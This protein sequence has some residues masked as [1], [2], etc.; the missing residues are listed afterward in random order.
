MQ[1]C[2]NCGTALPENA[3]FCAQCGLA[4]NLTTDTPTYSSNRMIYESTT[5]QSTGGSEKEEEEE[6]RRRMLLGLPLLGPM[7]GNAQPSAGNVP[8]VQGSPFSRGVPMVQ[9]TPPLAGAPSA[10]GASPA[11]NNPPPAMTHY[12]EPHHTA[13][14]PPHHPVAP[15]RPVPKHGPGLIPILVGIPVVV[16]IIIGG[17]LG[18]IFI[19]LPP[20]L[21]LSGDTISGGTLHLHGSNFFPGG[22]VALT[23]DNGQVLTLV[24]PGEPVTVS[25]TGTFDATISGTENWSVGQHTIHA[26]ESSGGRNGVLSFTLNANHTKVTPNISSFSSPGDAHCAYHGNQGWICQAAISTS[27]QALGNLIW[28]VSSSGLN[29]ITITPASG[30]LTPG[31]AQQVTMAIPN[32]VCPA[33]ATFIFTFKGGEDPVSVRWSC[34]VPKI[35]WDGVNCPQSNGYD[36]CPYVLKVAS[37]SEGLVDWTA[38]G[39]S[40]VI[41]IN[42]QSGTLAPGQSQPVSVA[43]PANPCTDTSWSVKDSAGNVF[44]AKLTC[45]PLAYKCC[46]PVTPCSV[47]F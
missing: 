11:S 44:P 42:P 24:S 18:T 43:F 37:G 34:A 8:V 5:S 39:N 33:S 41:R 15:F 3:Q 25:G 35:Y 32:T 16:I 23:L 14:P 9:G 30:S 36:V 40:P 27:S 45:V 31:Q 38:S 6:Q 17:I 20:S 47:F 1:R 12:G 46:W 21:S 13:P 7:I 2:Q 19:I 26:I 28:S 22:S 10:R 29:G 4:L